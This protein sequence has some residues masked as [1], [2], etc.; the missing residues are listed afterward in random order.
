MGSVPLGFPFDLFCYVLRYT[1]WRPRDVLK[2]YASLMTA[3]LSYP[4]NEMLSFEQIRLIVG[5][6]S[7]II[8]KTEFIG[9]FKEVITNLEKII[10]QFR[11]SK[12]R[13]NY[14]QVFQKLKDIDF[15]VMPQGIISDFREKLRILY[16]IGFLGLEISENMTEAA[17]RTKREC[18]YFNEG[19]AV[20]D[21]KAKYSFEDCY[22]LIHPIFVE[23]LQLDQ[24]DNSFILN[25]T[26]DYLRDNHIVR[27]AAL[28]GF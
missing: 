27:M 11:K 22:F 10:N 5:M 17:N 6:T 3:A 9:E 21:N 23:E 7:K 26:D 20:F 14:D 18:F 16:E 24:R 8:L 25:W 12:Q 4:G 28:D 15:S 13:L 1:F 19:L 2:Y